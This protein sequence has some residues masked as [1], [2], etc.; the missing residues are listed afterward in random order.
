MTIEFSRIS[1]VEGVRCSFLGVIGAGTFLRN[2][3]EL[4]ELSLMVRPFH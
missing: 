1:A 3:S 2:E 4:G